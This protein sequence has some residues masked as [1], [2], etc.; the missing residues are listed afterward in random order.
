MAEGVKWR[1]LRAAQVTESTVLCYLTQSVYF[2]FL[3]KLFD[4]IGKETHATGL[5]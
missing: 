2:A 5:Q 3:E 1:I 4:D